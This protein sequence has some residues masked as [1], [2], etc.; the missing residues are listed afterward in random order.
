[1]ELIHFEYH[2]N[3]NLGD[4]VIAMGEFD[5]LHLAHQE[6]IN[7]AISYAKKINAKSAVFSFD[8]HPDFVLK[9][10]NNQ[11]Y[12]TPL[13]VKIKALETLG[14]DYFVLIPFTLEFSKVLPHEFE[15]RV[16]SKF[17]IKRIVVGFDYRYGYRGSGNADTLKQNFDV[18]VVQQI[19]FMNQKMGSNEIR[20]LLLQGKIHEVTQMLGRYYN[21]TGRVVSGNK[22]G[23]KMGIRT[24]NV[25]LEEHYQILRKGVYAVFVNL[26]NR[27]YLGVCNIGNNPTVNYVEVPRL[28]V[29]I[30]SFDEIIYNEIIS[31]D[32]V[33]FLRDEIKFD[34]VDELINQINEDIM[35]TREILEENQ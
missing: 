35:K 8:P 31:V 6:L 27:K 33:E 14:V 2:K 17:S 23:R 7:R 5:G 26:N 1:M 22:V 3:Y 19:D 20:E 29:H 10:R 21:I 13:N 12:I 25:T 28:E 24:A 15:E 11:G 18:D 30:L 34:S 9:K 4:L 32:F 16:L